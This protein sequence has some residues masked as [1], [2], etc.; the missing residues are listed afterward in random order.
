MEATSFPMATEHSRVPVLGC[1]DKA[2][3][4]VPPCNERACEPSLLFQFVN[5]LLHLPMRIGNALLLLYYCYLLKIH[6]DQALQYIR[7][8]VQ[9]QRSTSTSCQAARV[10]TCQSDEKCS[11]KS[12]TK[13]LRSKK[14]NTRTVQDNYVQYS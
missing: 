3:R 13:F 11:R 14:I 10:L 8:T 2:T 6:G 4:S 9:L 5:V 12:Y 7:R 1:E